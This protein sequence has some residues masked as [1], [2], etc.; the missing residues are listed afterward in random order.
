MQHQLSYVLP[1][2][3]ESD[4]G[5]DELAGYLHWLAERVEVLVADGSS[6][7]AWERHAQAWGPAIRQLRPD[8]RRDYLNGKVGGVIAGVEA[9]S[10]EFVII[11]DDDVRY[12]APALARIVSELQE[13]DLVQ[14]QNYFDP[15]PWHAL[16]DTARSLVNRAIGAD[17]P[18]TFALRRST[19]LRLH[20]YDGDVLFENLELIRTVQAAG[21]TVASR[22]D[23]YVARR[24]PSTQRFWRQ[25]VHQAYDDF[26][27]PG[28][29]AA[30]LGILPSLCWLGRR[31]PRAL[32]AVAAATM[33][34]AEFGRRR[35]GGRSVF[36]ATASAFAPVWLL[37][38]AV[39]SWLAVGSRVVLGGY[40]YR[41]S[42]IR[43]A[44]HS[45]RELRRRRQLASGPAPGVAG[46]APPAC[47]SR[48]TTA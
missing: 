38:R 45:P 16:W 40:R 47:E 27:L 3:W 7:D 12:D 4:D 2:R 9:A 33:A 22:P 35:N 34:L 17:Y 14:P 13:A 41:E 23:L 48:R 8:R 1:L 36:P 46:G 29:L 10:H 24:P 43:C 26:A 44:A 15:L 28:R 30:G 39:C 6:P 11:G 25:R 31:H 20:G 37:E 5:L 42:V 19:F 32:L 21:G 18:G